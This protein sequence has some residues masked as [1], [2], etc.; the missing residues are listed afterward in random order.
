[1]TEVG[2]RLKE[3]RTEKNLSLEELQNITKIQKRYLQNV[4]EGNF[5]ALP[6]VFYARAFVKQYAE[7]VGLDPE[8]IFEEYKHE[9]PSTQ[10]EAIP[11]HLSRVKR[12][13]DE[14]NASTSKVFQIFPKVLVAVVIIGIAITVW[15]L[16][17]NSQNNQVQ[18]SP[19]TET[20][21]SEIEKNNNDPL[22]TAAKEEKEDKE[23]EKQEDDTDQVASTGE[24]AD[25][26][27]VNAE[28]EVQFTQQIHL[29]QSTGKNSTYTLSN[30]DKFVVEVSTTTETWLDLKNGKNKKFYSALLN[31]KETDDIP[32]VTS[33]DFTNEEVAVIR[34]GYAETATIKVNGQVVEIP[35]EPK[36]VQNITINFQKEAAQ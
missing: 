35:K 11:E 30:T 13:R 33:Y 7:A 18:E 14:V 28:D 6:G 16:L 27:Q 2:Q 21:S 22:K 25:E 3:A 15:T 9:I 29:V 8:M 26:D 32:N 34:L 23:K 1:M 4:E 10:K 12:T 24:E 36:S 5:D 20:Q 19:K 17:Q 31:N